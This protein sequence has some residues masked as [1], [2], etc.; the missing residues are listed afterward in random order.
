MSA[1]DNVSPALFGQL[2]HGTAGRMRKGTMITPGRASN[3]PGVTYDTRAEHVFATDDP[4]EAWGH[5]VNASQRKNAGKVYY[6]RGMDPEDLG[7]DPRD[8]ST[9]PRPLY[10]PSAPRVYPV[11]PTGPIQGDPEMTTQ[12]WEVHDINDMDFEGD[13][14]TAVQSKHPFE[15]TGKDQG[16]EFQQQY[17]D[18]MGVDANPWHNP[19][20]HINNAVGVHDDAPQMRNMNRDQFDW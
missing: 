6:R 15:V 3:Y 17:R 20:D 13:R 10:R 9:M 19:L 1:E 14:A 2:Y 18:E 16:A 7:A 4:M 5:A 12:G 11:K 8:L